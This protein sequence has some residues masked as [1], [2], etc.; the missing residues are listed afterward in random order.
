MEND[1]LFSIIG[2]IVGVVVGYYAVDIYH[3]SK[4]WLLKR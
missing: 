2:V 3:W 1:I 4:E